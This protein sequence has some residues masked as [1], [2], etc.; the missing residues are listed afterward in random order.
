MYIFIIEQMLYNYKINKSI[1][2]KKMSL[3]FLNT[4]IIFHQVS[5]YYEKFLKLQKMTHL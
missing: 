1:Y 2:K 3:I 5:F 4:S